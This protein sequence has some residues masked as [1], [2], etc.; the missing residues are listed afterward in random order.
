MDAR[1][2]AH[3]HDVV[4]GIHGVLVVLHHDE[5]IPQVAQALERGQKLGVVALVQADGGL[6]EDVEHAHQAGTDLRS[7]ADAL[8]LAAGKGGRRARQREVGQAHAVQKA[9]A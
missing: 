7:Q 1:A 2:G 3:V 6:V 5:R 4:G 8:R 9:Q